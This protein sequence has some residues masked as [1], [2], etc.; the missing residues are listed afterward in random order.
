MREVHRALDGD[1]PAPFLL[2]LGRLTKRFACTPMRVI[3]ELQN[4]PDRLMF[5]ILE[6]DAYEAAKHQVDQAKGRDELPKTAIIELAI[7]NRLA[8]KHAVMKQRLAEGEAVRRARFERLLR[9][10]QKGMTGTPTTH[11]G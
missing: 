6:L 8:G 2:V 7:E 3:W 9:K 5:R 11:H 10:K 1:G 4:D